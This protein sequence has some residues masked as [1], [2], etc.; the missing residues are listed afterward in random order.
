MKKM[1][2]LLA[3]VLVVLGVG[4]SPAR[5]DLGGFTVTNPN[6]TWDG[7]DTFTVG[8]WSWTDGENV[9][10]TDSSLYR[11]IAPLGTA[12]FPIANWDGGDFY[13]EM[14]I[15]DI[16]TSTATGN[17]TFWFYDVDGDLL[18]GNIS[19]QWIKAGTGGIFNGSLSGVTFDA[20]T[21]DGHTGSVSMD[22]AAGQP[23]G[24]TF[25]Q[26]VPGSPTGQKSWFKPDVSFDVD[27][28]SIDATI[29]PVPA[30]LLIGLLGLG[31]A[32]LK[33]RKFA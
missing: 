21:F 22:F 28:G 11:S 13:A 31:T 6:T 16:H 14:T 5:A 10:G 12:S 29:T 3:M 17:G 25:I 30:A 33:L 19:G 15:S 26:V 20:D 24:G 18:T 9:A 8:T 23:W 32:G 2:C 7:V 27:G 4:L 1:S